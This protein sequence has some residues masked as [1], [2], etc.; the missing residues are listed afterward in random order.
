MAQC[1]QCKAKLNAHVNYWHQELTPTDN[2]NSR[3]DISKALPSWASEM[4]AFCSAKCLS[5]YL[6]GQGQSVAKL[7]GTPSGTGIVDLLREPFKYTN[8]TKQ[9]LDRRGF[10]ALQNKKVVNDITED[11]KIVNQTYDK[12]GAKNDGNKGDLRSQVGLATP[13][14]D[15]SQK[16]VFDKLKQLKDKE[17]METQA[18]TTKTCD[19]CK[20][21][22]D[23]KEDKGEMIKATLNDHSTQKNKQYDLC[24]EECLRQM[25]NG[26]SKKKKSKASIIELDMS[27]E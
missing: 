6:Q 1:R 10:N 5:S 4:A 7:D 15:A 9:E 13:E 20:C 3:E 14:E 17:N 24:S 8:I 12:K 23:A 22:L 2:Q 11:R 19:N 21:V 26:R 16:P 18:K 25:L 27:I